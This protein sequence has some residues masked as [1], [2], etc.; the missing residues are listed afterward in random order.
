MKDL[1][2]YFDHT[3]LKADA[4]LNQVKDLCKE[5]LDLGSAS[6]CVNSGFVSDCVTALKGSNVKVCAVVGFP[7]G[8]MATEIKVSFYL[9]SACYW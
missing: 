8:A 9:N 1:G 4:T 3:I 5:A 2:Y 7:L 6:V